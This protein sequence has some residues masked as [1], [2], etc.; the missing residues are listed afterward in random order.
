MKNDQVCIFGGRCHQCGRCRLGE[1]D[2]RKGRL[3]ILPEGFLEG[4]PGESAEGWGAAFD[5]GTTTVVGMLWDLKEHRLQKIVSAANPQAK[6]GQDVISRINYCMENEGGLQALHQQI[7]ASMNELLTQMTA[8]AETKPVLRMTAV[9]NTT[10]CHLLL[11][12]DPS[13]LARAPYEPAYRGS[14]RI[15]AASLGIKVGHQV[16]L[17]L[18]PGIAGHVGSDITAGL[19]ASGLPERN[20]T[21]LYI[22]VG[23]NGEIVLV[24]EGKLTACSAAAGPAFEGASIRCGAR[25]AR[26]VIEA[27]RLTDQGVRCQTIGDEPSSG[28]CGSGL[29]DAVAQFLKWGIV[30][31]KGRMRKPGEASHLPKALEEALYLDN[32]SPAFRLSETVSIC[33]QDIREVQLAKGAILAGCHI[34]L[35]EAGKTAEDLDDVWIAGAFGSSIDRNSAL[36]MGLIPPVALDRVLAAGNAA[37]AGASMAVLAPETIKTAEAAAARTRHV[38]LAAH[39]DFELRYARAMYFPK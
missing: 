18:L 2:D 22:D 4:L 11:A 36:G 28:I 34:L 8:G 25:A 7:V 31:P 17:L 39:P 27:V 1:T 26:G 15:P 13:S 29:I 19:I 5:I 16:E 21:H 10:M 24:S 23:T 35:E 14:V 9:G 32:G 6:Y 3:T 12:R 33:Q 20:G 37:G 30:D 38:S